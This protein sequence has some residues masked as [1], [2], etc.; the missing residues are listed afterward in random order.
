MEEIRTFSDLHE[1]LGQRPVGSTYFRGVRKA[2]YQLI[3][4]VG[5]LSHYSLEL[6][7]SLLY[8]FKINATPY[9]DPRPS[10]DWEWLAIAQHHGIPTRLLD[11]TRNVLVAAYFAVEGNSI[12]PSAIYAYDPGGLVLDPKQQ[13]PFK[14]K[15]SG[16]YLP[17]HFTARIAAQSGTFT[18]QP[19]P[20]APFAPAGVEKFV[21]AEEAKLPLR[22]ALYAYGVHRGSLF[23][24]PDG[25]A[26]MIYWLTTKEDP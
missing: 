6:E 12:G 17:E 16:I 5:R 10:S 20:T 1:A 14:V 2:S 13:D 26:R 3:P 8:L 4:K 9:L 25:Q 21:I 23:P 11:W 7:S 22:K 18:V 19:K 24:D 15:E